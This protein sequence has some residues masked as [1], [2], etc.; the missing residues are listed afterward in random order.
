MCYMQIVLVL[1]SITGDHTVCRLTWLPGQPE[2]SMA[3]ANPE[4]EIL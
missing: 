1:H 2:G 3:I 4:G